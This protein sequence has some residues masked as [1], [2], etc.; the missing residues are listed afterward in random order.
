MTLWEFVLKSWV[1][2][3]EFSSSEKKLKFLSV[4]CDL[5]G[6]TNIHLVALSLAFSFPL[7]MYVVKFSKKKSETPT[8]TFSTIFVHGIL[9]LK[10]YPATSSCLSLH[11]CW[12][13]F[14]PLVETTVLCPRSLSLLCESDCTSRQKAGVIRWPSSSPC[15][16]P[17]FQESPSRIAGVQYLKIIISYILSRFAVF[18]GF[19]GGRGGR[20]G[21]SIMATW[22]VLK[23]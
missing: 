1:I 22:N 7:C 10:F 18:W 12:P 17:I 20:D 11:E 4:L 21:K 9:L 5:S 19:S 14:L 16:F 8:Q 2:N 6:P 23:S 15:L 13:R 3:K